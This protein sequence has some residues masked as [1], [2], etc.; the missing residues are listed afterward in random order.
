MSLHT[1]LPLCYHQLIC[2]K[3]VTWLSQGCNNIVTTLCIEV[4]CICLL[5]GGI[6][7][8]VC[9]NRA[10]YLYVHLYVVNLNL[11]TNFPSGSDNH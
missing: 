6:V 2:H 5:F 11:L 1:C 9:T 8:V 10:F 3:V 4:D 7:S